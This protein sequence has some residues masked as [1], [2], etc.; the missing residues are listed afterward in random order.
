MGNSSP[1]IENDERTWIEEIEVSG[2]K[3]KEKVESLAAEASVRRIRIKEPDGDIAVDIPLTIGAVAGGAIVLA[4]PILA[5]IGA[6]AAFFSK[7]TV[8]IVREETAE[9]E[10]EEA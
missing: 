1:K 7:V 8:E 10:T 3:L 5:L 2:E 9:K 4:A 6:V